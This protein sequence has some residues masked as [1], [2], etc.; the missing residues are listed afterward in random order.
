VAKRRSWRQPKTKHM[1]QPGNC[2]T[3]TAPLVRVS[4]PD[5]LEHFPIRSSMSEVS[6]AFSGGEALERGTDYRRDRAQRPLASRAE[7]GLELGE[8]VSS[9]TP[10]SG[11]DPVT[12][13]EGVEWGERLVHAGM[14]A[15]DVEEGP[16]LRVRL[17]SPGRSARQLSGSASW[18][19]A[20]LIR[21]Q[22]R[23]RSQDIARPIKATRRVLIRTWSIRTTLT[24]RTP[25][26]RMIPTRRITRLPINQLAKLNPL[27]RQIKAPERDSSQAAGAE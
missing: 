9:E 4:S 22:P 15:H 26:S 16:L 10:E 14:I 6:G 2:F 3:G 12:A 8:A 17:P 21:R 20:R 5:H 23:R 13:R 7:E 11:T 1:T 25:R 19:S 24:R 27:P 18:P